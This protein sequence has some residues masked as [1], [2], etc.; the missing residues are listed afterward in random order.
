MPFVQAAR[1]G[2][3]TALVLFPRALLR[4]CP[5]TPKDGTG[6]AVARVLGVRHLLQA[7]V[8]A[9]GTLPPAWA[10]VPDAVHA[11]SMAA[12]A[13]RGD[14]WRA[15]ALTD[16]CVAS[17]FAA[18]SWRGERAGAPPDPPASPSRT[19]VRRGSRC[20]PGGFRPP[21]RDTPPA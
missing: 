16:L 17:A 18:A 8:T 6:A 2:W 10:A 14:R 15:A 21:G 12:L 5:A 7:A 13:L 1:V 20:W 19:G 11:A 4:R 3:G 9:R